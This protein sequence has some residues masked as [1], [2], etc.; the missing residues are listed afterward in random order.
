MQGERANLRNERE[1]EGSDHCRGIYYCKTI[2]ATS[3]IERKLQVAGERLK[4]HRF[5]VH[6]DKCFFG[7]LVDNKCRLL[8]ARQ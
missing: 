5:F 6:Q 8:I 2:N 4:K 3:A 1:R 7:A